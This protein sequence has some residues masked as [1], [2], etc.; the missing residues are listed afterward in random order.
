MRQLLPAITP[1]LLVKHDLIVSGGWGPSEASPSTRQRD[2]L[3]ASGRLTSFKL[4]GEEA[5]C[6]REVAGVSIVDAGGLCSQ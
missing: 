5:G 1:S 3:D 6:F 2:T 4:K